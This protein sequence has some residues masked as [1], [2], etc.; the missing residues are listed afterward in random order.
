[1]NC[2]N[3]RIAKPSG[4]FSNSSFFKNFICNFIRFI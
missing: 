1:M 3:T 2:R 4:T